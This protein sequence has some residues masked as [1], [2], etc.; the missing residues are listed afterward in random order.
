M[1]KMIVST[2]I[3]MTVTA[4]AHAWSF[5]TVKADMMRTN[6][7]CIV[8]ASAVKIE[9]KEA[10]TFSNYAP[11]EIGEYQ[12]TPVF[13]GIYK[14]LR[15]A[16]SDQLDDVK[17]LDLGTSKGITS[18]TLALP[19]ANGEIQHCIVKMDVTQVRVRP[20]LLIP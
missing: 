1:K 5:F 12:F 7:Q 11:M 19:K 4:Q 17:E 18:V 14:V 3:L 2:A 13:R 20:S 9:K 10:L 15:I 6:I 16:K 8:D